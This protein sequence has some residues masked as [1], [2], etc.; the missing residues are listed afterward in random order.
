MP[1]DTTDFLTD[2]AT[3]GCGPSFHTEIRLVDRPLRDMF[4]DGA[5]SI[6]EH[7]DIDGAY[8]RTELIGDRDHRASDWRAMELAYGCWHL[9]QATVVGVLMLPALPHHVDS[10][11]VLSVP[12]SH[13][14]HAFGEYPWFSLEEGVTEDVTR[15]H[16]LVIAH[17]MNLH[18][19]VPVECVVIRDEAWPCLVKPTDQ[20][21]FVA[22]EIGL[23]MGLE[24]EVIE[25]ELYCIPLSECEGRL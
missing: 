24:G 12:P 25:D 9:D 22:K 6:L 23:A 15:L 10:D 3:W 4:A 17:V 20:G 7:L 14:D 13:V 8:G 2:Q 19:H 11:F 1:D 5:Q 18:R 16:R 21:V